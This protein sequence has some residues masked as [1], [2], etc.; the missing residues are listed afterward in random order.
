MMK[1]SFGLQDYLY[2]DW[3]KIEQFRDEEII[4]KL[5]SVDI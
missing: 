5:G 4:E 3:N 1:N 2:E